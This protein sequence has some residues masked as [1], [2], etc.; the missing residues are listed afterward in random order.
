MK[1]FAHRGWALGEIENTLVG[2]EKSAQAGFDGVEF[3]VRFGPD[4]RTVI[5]SHNAATGSVPTLTLGEALTHLQ[6][7]DMEL[8]IEFKE[9][10]DKLFELVIE[11]L[12][13]HYLLSK[14]TIFAF[15]EIA[16]L[17]PWTNRA[18][19]KLGI[20]APYPQ[21]I[22]KYIRLYYP[23]M[24]LMGWGTKKERL[25]F[26]IVWSVMSLKKIFKKYANVKFVIGV[27]F[28]EKDKAWLSKQSGLYGFT[29]DM[30]LL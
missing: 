27:A 14:A 4:G 9:Y 23:D 6:S 10:S 19:V 3:D 1:T 28:Q 15:P 17:F 16:A 21:D 20:I 8:L 26:K 11:H 2:F 7:S 5:L 13:Q 30:P 24:V 25:Q 18:G 12:Q 29:G 22:E